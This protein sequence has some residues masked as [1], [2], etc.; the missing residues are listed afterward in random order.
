MRGKMMKWVIVCV[1]LAAAFSSLSCDTNT[2]ISEIVES[3]CY[4]NETPAI[5]QIY[6]YRAKRTPKTP[7]THRSMNRR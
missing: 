4:Q 7:D 5:S 2:E 1:A 6:F 3:E